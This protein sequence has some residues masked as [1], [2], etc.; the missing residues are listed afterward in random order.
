MTYNVRTRAYRCIIVDYWVGRRGECVIG[1]SLADGRVP[2]VL[3]GVGY[4][5]LE[6]LVGA[7]CA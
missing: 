2:F 1:G 7:R 4:D 3:G 5:L 6:A